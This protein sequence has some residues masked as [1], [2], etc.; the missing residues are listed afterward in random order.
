MKTLPSST[1][2]ICNTEVLQY[3]VDNFRRAYETGKT[4]VNGAKRNDIKRAFGEQYTTVNLT[5]R[6][7]V[8][9]IEHN[10]LEFLVFNSKS[11]TSV[12]LVDDN[13]N[14]LGECDKKTI[15]AMISFVDMFYEKVNLCQ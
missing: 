11:G 2:I 12:E 9:K 15:K 13:T 1:P 3:M 8:W 5:Y 14:Y 4:S 6:N 10:G 7:W